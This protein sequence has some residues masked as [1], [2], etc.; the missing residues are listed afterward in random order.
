LKP[1]NAT[2]VP[3][4]KEIVFS[5]AAVGGGAGLW[6]LP[7]SGNGQPARLPFVGEDGAMPA[8]S[9]SQ[10]GRPARLVYVRSF[11][12]ENIWRIDT[13][14]AGAAAS[15]PPVI[16]IAS[17][18]ADVHPQLSPDGRRV[19]FTTTR[20]G[21][22]EIWVSDTDGSNTVQITFLGAP[23]GTGVPHWSPDGRLLVFASDAEGQFDIFVVASAGGKPRNITSHPAIEHV[24]GFSRD[25]QWVYFSSA[26]TGE[27]QIWKV[28]I[29]GGEAVQVT[30]EGGWLSQESV[31]GAYL[32]FT[33]TAAV[34][35]ST[36]LWRMPTSGGQPVKV[37]GSV[38]NTTFVVLQHGI[39]YVDLPS[40]EARLQYFDF[41][42]RTSVTVA[43]SLGAGADFN[44]LAVSS[45]G[46]TILYARLDSAVDDLMLVENVR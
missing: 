8:F 5:T 1:E 2:W 32:Y 3:N 6:K 10:P 17:T 33:P 29:S 45:D 27:F 44:G 15:S 43:R 35:A 12:D 46:R 14:A 24:P 4:G 13:T 42:S 20:S 30:K 18:K 36:Q 9:R 21:A 34:S 28:P 23:T 25:G 31:D 40:T 41:A 11:T 22:W 37:L 38:L 7:A 39:Y 26:R 19:A 16:A